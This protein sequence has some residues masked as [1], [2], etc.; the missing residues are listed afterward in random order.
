MLGTL[1]DM[2]MHF[3]TCQ[4]FEAG[5]HCCRYTI[6][7]NGRQRLYMPNSK[8][9]TSEFMVME[10]KKQER[11]RGFGPR[12][13]DQPDSGT[14]PDL[15]RPLGPG[16]AYGRWGEELERQ[17][18]M[19]A[20]RCLPLSL[21]LLLSLACAAA[22]AFALCLL[23][24]SVVIVFHVTILPSVVFLVVA[25][26]PCLLAHASTQGMSVWSCAKGAPAWM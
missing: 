21:P 15:T 13:S 20:S 4:Q 7:R 12:Y 17:R 14:R 26:S 22:G 25:A 19:A 11:G 5:R 8:F 1:L 24:P 9:L 3:S 10:G 16:M 18:I 6:I 2:G 23:M